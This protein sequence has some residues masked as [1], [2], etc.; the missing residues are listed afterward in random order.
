MI[1]AVAAVRG[2]GRGDRPA[3][4]ARAPAQSGLGRASAAWA[5]RRTPCRACPRWRPRPSRRPAR[6]ERE[7]LHLGMVLA[8]RPQDAR[9][10][11]LHSVS[12]L[13]DPSHRVPRSPRCTLL[14]G[15]ARGLGRRE[16]REAS[17]AANSASMPRREALCP[18]LSPPRYSALQRGGQC[19]DVDGTAGGVEA[20]DD[21]L[22]ALL[23]PRHEVLD[24][25]RRAPRRAVDD[26]DAVLPAHARA[27]GPFGPFLAFH[28]PRT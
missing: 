1:P 5:A 28:T 24:S 2:D 9:D 26:P 4:S 22:T 13:R 6:V 14:Y 12:R 19:G 8:E 17:A 20:H 27:V 23:G 15:L 3:G 7:H 10:A 25:S 16:R 11:E 18:N 21:D